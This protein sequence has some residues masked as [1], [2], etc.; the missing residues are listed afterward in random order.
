MKRPVKYRTAASWRVA[1]CAVVLE[2]ALTD[3]VC[4]FGWFRTEPAMQAPFGRTL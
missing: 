4:S 1:G 2:I 3:G